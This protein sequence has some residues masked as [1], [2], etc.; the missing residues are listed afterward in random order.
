MLKPHL[1]STDVEEFRLEDVVV[2]FE[3]LIQYWIQLFVDDVHLSAR[4]LNAELLPGLL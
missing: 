3:D 4:R 1:V 2:L